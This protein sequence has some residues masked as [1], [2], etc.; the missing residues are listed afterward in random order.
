MGNRSSRRPRRNESGSARA[1]GGARRRLGASWCAALVTA[2]LCLLASTAAV[3]FATP[4]AESPFSAHLV[5]AYHDKSL[6][7]FILV[8]PVGLLFVIRNA[9]LVVRITGGIFAG[10]VVAQVVAARI[11]GSVPDYLHIETGIRNFG[12]IAN[13]ADILML[14]SIIVLIPYAL[15]GALTRGWHA[16]R[17]PAPRAAAPEQIKRPPP[18]D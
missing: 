10:G 11:W 2:A 4:V 5:L 15:A 8:L 7:L 1:G 6:P 3:A 17:F 16:M 9:P 12:V 18:D 13:A 14:T